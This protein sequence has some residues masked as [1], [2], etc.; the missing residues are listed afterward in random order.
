M[1]VSGQ[2][3]LQCTHASNILE[4]YAWSKSTYNPYS[5]CIS[6]LQKKSLKHWSGYCQRGCVPNINTVL[7]SNVLMIYRPYLTYILDTILEGMVGSRL[8]GPIIIPVYE[9]SVNCNEGTSNKEYV[10]HLK[11]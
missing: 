3:L 7:I 5:R 1:H 11:S 10:L 6:C 2:G 8:I 9:R 4:H